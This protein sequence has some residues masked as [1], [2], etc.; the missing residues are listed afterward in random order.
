[1]RCEIACVLFAMSCMLETRASENGLEE[2]KW[3][4][5]HSPRVKGVRESRTDSTDICFV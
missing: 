1:M 2:K 4:N 3:G 5:D